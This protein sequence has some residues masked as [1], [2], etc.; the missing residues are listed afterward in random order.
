MTAADWV[1]WNEGCCINCNE[2]RDINDE[3]IC[4]L[5][6]D[7]TDGADPDFEFGPEELW[8]WPTW[9]EDDDTYYLQ[10]DEYLERVAVE[11]YE[12]ER[13]KK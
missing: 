3:Y 6:V 9:V 11:E 2:V 7:G 1:Y 10:L 4:Y 13:Q 5:C 12:K 8:E